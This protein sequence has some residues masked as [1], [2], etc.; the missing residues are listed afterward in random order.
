MILEHLDK[1]C[2]LNVLRHESELLRES[3]HGHRELFVIFALIPTLFDLLWVTL[4]S[5]QPIFCYK[6][7]EIGSKC[8]RKEEGLPCNSISLTSVFLWGY[9]IHDIVKIGLKTFICEKSI[10]LIEYEK[11]QVLKIFNKV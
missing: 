4:Y 9:Y 6:S 2:F 1:I 5:K 11:L 8:C 7:I 3:F 10:S